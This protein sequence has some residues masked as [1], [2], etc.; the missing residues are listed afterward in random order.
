[1]VGVGLIAA[2]LSG[3]AGC[4]G[5]DD[6][7][8]AT[9]DS[10]QSDDDGSTTTADPAADSAAYCDA[11]LALETAGDPEIDFETMTPEQQ[12]EAA[13]TFA[14]ET[15][16]PL[17][18][19]LAPT[20]PPELEQQFT[21]LDGAVTQLEATGDPSAFES[22]EV[23]AASAAA[24]AYDLENCDW[25]SQAVTTTEYQFSGIPDS[26]DAGVT[27]FDLTNDGA[28]VHEMVLLRKNDG[29]TESADEILAL[30]QEEGLQ[31]ATILGTAGPVP[32]GETAYLVADLD[33][34][35]Y[36]AVC[37]IPVGTTSL[38]TAP[39]DAP[40]HFTQGMVT[41]FSVS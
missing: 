33:A 27:S 7:D 22:P 14:T 37:F 30:P 8:A 36:I 31:K 35:D 38:D 2:L 23:V 15:L 26:L 40:P 41:E 12:A 9:D 17:V 6:D 28:E 13:K 19:D 18:D 11:E 24:H 25:T 21:A 32:A 1:M 3:A 39:P 10:G 29:V 34:A 4:G 20:V 5:D 16:R